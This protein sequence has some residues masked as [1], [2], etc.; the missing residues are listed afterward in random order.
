MK[1]SIQDSEEICNSLKTRDLYETVTGYALEYIMAIILSI[2][3]AGY[4]GK[5]V[6]MEQHS[7]RHR[8]SISRF[9]RN[10]EWDD[11]GL[12][13]AMKALVIKTIYEESE[14][15][16]KPI[17]CI[18]D[19]TIASKTKPSSRAKHPIESALFHYSHLKKKQDYGHQAVGVLLSCNGIT[20]P[21]GMIMYDKTVSKID[22]AAQIAR[23][24]PAAPNL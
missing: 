11:S 8:T 3:S 13:G 17:Y 24:L 2:F 14:R 15:S 7:E 9:L 18:I 23:E 5:T 6:D 10:E 12:E 22:I 1:K 21:Y 20:L 16:G 4:R 19:D